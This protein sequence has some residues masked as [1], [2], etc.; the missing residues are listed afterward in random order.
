[1]MDWAPRRHPSLL[2]LGSAGGNEP[3]THELVRGMIVIRVPFAISSSAQPL[4]Q[5]EQDVMVTSG[6]ER[7]TEIDD[8]KDLFWIWP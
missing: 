6:T 8:N 5:I 4:M 7:D 1:M 3:H 2:I